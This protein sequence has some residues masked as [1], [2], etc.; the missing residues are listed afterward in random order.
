MTALVLGFQFTLGDARSY[1]PIVCRRRKERRVG[2]TVS[3]RGSR[4]F[5]IKRLDICGLWACGEW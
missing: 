5:L 3:L 1:C 2:R 4:T